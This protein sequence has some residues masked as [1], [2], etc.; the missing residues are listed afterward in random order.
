MNTSSVILHEM[1]A[2]SNSFYIIMECS[3]IGIQAI[4]MLK[5]DDK[6]YIVPNKRRMTRSIM[7]KIQQNCLHF[8]N[9]VLK[10]NEAGKHV[11]YM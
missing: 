8:V 4:P 7:T 6:T 1:C 5:K 9:L 10:R 3:Y 2:L 11:L